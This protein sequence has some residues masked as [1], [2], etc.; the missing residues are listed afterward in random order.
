MTQIKAKRIE[1]TRAEGT[2][3]LDDFR[4]YTFFIGDFQDIWQAANDHLAVM[5][6][7]VS[8]NGTS[9]KVDFKV[10]F[11]DGQEYNGTY[12]LKHHSI[13]KADLGQHMAGF[14]SFYAGIKPDHLTQEEYDH[15]LSMTDEEVKVSARKS[16]EELEIVTA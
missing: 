8:Q 9:D 4:P 10:T 7:T 6:D 13:E 12:C 2:T 16:L 3:N 15:F 11:Y 1:M 14:L 5:S